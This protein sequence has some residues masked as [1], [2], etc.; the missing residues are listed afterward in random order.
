MKTP[1]MKELLE[2]GAHFGHQSRRWNPKMGQYIFG[3]RS[4]VHII[5]LE[6]TEEKLTAAADFV[7]KTVEEGG[8]IVFLATK[9]QAQEIVKA[10]AERAGAMYMV[11]RW[12]GG[13]FTNFEAVRKTIEKMPALEGMIADTAKFTKKEQLLMSRELAKLNRYAGGVRSM[14]KLP[15]VLFLIDARKEDN[16]VREARKMGV[17]T[18]AVVDTNADPT[19]V[20]YPI[21]ANDDAIKSI[22]LVV[23]TIA[24]AVEEGKAAF[25]K[26]QEKEAKKAGKEEE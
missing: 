1:S 2:A 7:K 9:R 16:A 24:D 12:L 10:E 18:V 26:K 3:E 23:K 25:Q 22:S 15:E 11:E 19:M 4:G 20:D 13:L 6:K 17:K 8:Q 21:P 14:E 5:D